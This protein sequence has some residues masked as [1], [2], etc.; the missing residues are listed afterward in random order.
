M[1]KI[2]TYGQECEKCGYQWFSRKEKPKS[3][4]ECKTRLKNQWKSK[5]EKPKNQND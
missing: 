5:V 1:K 2:I 3:C 4:P